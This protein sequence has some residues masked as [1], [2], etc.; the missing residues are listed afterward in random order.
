MAKNRSLWAELQREQARRQR[1]RQQ[2]LRMEVQA[3]ARARRDHE[4][5]ARAAA[6][7]AAADAKERRRL[8][9]EERKAEAASMVME[10]Q[11][12]V[13]ELD[14]ALTAGIQQGPL[15]TF[16]SLKRSPSYPP[17]DAGGLER[18][19]AAPSWEQFAPPPPGGLGK[20]FG[21]S[22]RHERQEA[23]ARAAYEAELR[24]HAT[25]EAER[26]GKLAERRAAYDRAAAAAVSAAQD[27]NAGVDQLERD[28]LAREPEAVAE[29]CT[30][31]LDSSLYPEGF[32]HRTRVL[33]RPEPRE[34]AVEYELPPQSVIPAE[35]D[36]KY[37]AARDEIDTLS[38]P[39]KE[40]KDR[41]ARLIAQTAIRTIH[42]VLVSVPANIATIV[43]FYGH[44]S[45]TDLATGQPTSSSR[46]W[47]P[48]PA[49]TAAPISST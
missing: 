29:L 7:Q 1:Q 47:T 25:A 3:A 6:R 42:E 49:W 4:Q 5:A 16:A 46:A 20:I 28:F 33:Y 2:A 24:K 41:Y 38:R 35:R 31:V 22:A 23:A 43:T 45:T 48:S 27:H 10:L 34:V 11:A 14:S 32:A 12:R 30:L 17:F 37:V 18:P 9:V 19:S 40:I 13:A 8:Y 36:Y 26:R 21:G 39:E 15:V 44:V